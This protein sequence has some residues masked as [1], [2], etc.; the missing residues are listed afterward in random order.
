MY[1]IAAKVLTTKATAPAS[2]R[3]AG[4]LTAG[5]GAGAGAASAGAGAGAADALGMLYTTTKENETPTTIAVLLECEVDELVL[6]N[7]GRYPGLNVRCA[8]F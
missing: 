7:L 1:Q 2:I 4:A 6:L 3:T 8:L 5:A